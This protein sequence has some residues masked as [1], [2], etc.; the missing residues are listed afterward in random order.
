MTEAIALERYIRSIA[1]WPKKGILFRDITPLLGDPVAFTAAINS[2]C[3]DFTEAGVEYFWRGCCEKA[4]C[5]ICAH[6]KEGQAS[7]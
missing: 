5:R 6:K 4:R 3:S 2:L 1:D 7:F